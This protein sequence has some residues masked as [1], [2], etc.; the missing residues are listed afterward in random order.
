MSGSISVNP[1]LQTQPQASFLA[2]TQ[3]YVQGF[4]HDDPSARME[5]ATGQLASSETLVMWGGVPLTEQINITGSGSE[6][7]GPQLKRA[8]AV[9]NVTA[10][11]V[12]NQATAMLITP[13][14][15]AP[16]T[17]I[18]G[19]VP[20]FRNL[21]RARIAVQADPALVAAVSGEFVGQPALFWDTTNFRITLTSG[22]AFFALPATTQILSVNT[23]SKIVQVVSGAPQWT[24]GDAAIILI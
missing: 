12:Y 6:G 10:W 13:G 2:E 8:T 24:T 14:P 3:G 9:G 5:L 18:G 11:S 22:G 20:F 21:S 7:N 23:N 19:T 1:W 4:A 16:S 17:S 15:S